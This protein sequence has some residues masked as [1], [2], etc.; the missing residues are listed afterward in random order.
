M[1]TAQSLA[2]PNTQV[3]DLT[4]YEHAD[5]SYAPRTRE[6]AQGADVTVAFAVDYT[7]A[8]E[9][10]TARV[11]GDRFIKIPYGGDVA[12]AAKKLA[13]FLAEREGDS[14]NVAGNGIYTFAAHGIGQAQINRWVFDVLAKV[15]AMVKLSFIRS[16]GQTGA[17][18]AGLVA[19]L[20]LGI[21]AVGLYPAGYRRRLLDG[22]DVRSKPSPLEAELRAQA[23]ALL[24]GAAPSRQFHPDGTLPQDG[25]VFVFGSN[26]AGRHGAGSALVAKEQFGAIQFQGKGRMGQSY[27]IPTKD[28][29]NRADLKDPAQ[30]RAVADINVD[31]TE[32]VAYAKANPATKFFVTRLGCVLAAHTDAD[33][34]PLFRAA[35]ANCSFPECWKPWLAEAAAPGS[36]EAVV[37]GINIWSGAKGLGGALTNMSE[38]ARQK[39]CIKHSYPVQVN[40]V[41]YPDSEAAYQA[42]KVPD[43]VPYN[44][45]LMI[46]IICLKFLQ[47]TKLQ[48]LVT[49]RGG[50]PWLGR[51]SHHTNAQSARFQSWEGQG[52]SSRFIRNLIHGYQK[53]LSGEGPE[54]RAVHVK[55][56]PFDVYIG[57]KNGDLPESIWAN[58]WVIGKDGTRDEVV[59]RYYR[60][61]KSSPDLMARV[62]E[63]RFKTLGCWCKTRKEPLTLCHGDV[64]AALA[65]GREW[66]APNPVQ[67]SLF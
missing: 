40:G 57:R 59:A 30:T 13:G 31:V 5:F 63:L 20:A 36:S 24:P 58:P 62:H 52:I 25:A 51:C 34:A 3:P 1:A 38:L 32:F 26:L 67:K 8:G 21:P 11:A 35:P 55:E 42:L 48:R 49:E 22:Q 43:N 16:G 6:N 60:H 54:T 19:S 53:S 7:T 46:D 56:A 14:L 37:E 66:E 9:R 17:D 61:V 50:V 15:S 39:G 47:N 64:L 2:A 4:L 18:Q 23:A 10:L 65:D 41:R 45:G 12:E 27:G 28:G 33:I 29:R 44:D